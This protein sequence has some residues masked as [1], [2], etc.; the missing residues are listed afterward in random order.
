MNYEYYNPGLKKKIS[1]EVPDNKS[2]VLIYGKNGSGKTVFSES[3][4]FNKKYVFNEKFVREN[5]YI[6]TE[7]DLKTTASNRENFSSLFMGKDVVKLKEKLDLL[8]SSKRNYSTKREKHISIIKDKLD[9]TKIET[10]YNSVINL[11][12][13]NVEPINEL[14]EYDELLKE[15]KIKKYK[16]TIKD[17][18]KFEEKL[19]LFN[20]N[21]KIQSYINLVKE[22]TILENIVLNKDLS[23]YKKIFEEIE[24]LQKMSSIKK[25]MDS[26]LLKRKINYLK[27]DTKTIE[28][29]LKM[30][31]SNNICL[32][33]GAEDKLKEIKKWTNIISNKFEVKKQSIL[34]IIKNLLKDIE[35][36]KPLEKDVSQEIPNTV[37]IIADIKKELLGTKIKLEKSELEI[38]S[39]IKLIE[40]EELGKEVDE[41]Q[42]EL[43]DFLVFKEKEK[44]LGTEFQIKNQENSI[45]KTKKELEHEFEMLKDEVIERTNEILSKM[46]IDRKVNIKPNKR[47]YTLEFEIDGKDVNSLS[48]GERH[49]LAIAFFFASLEDEDLDNKTIVLDDPVVTLDEVSYHVLRK[50]IIKLRK[51][52]KDKNLKVIILTHNIFYLYVQISNLFENNDLKDEAIFFKMTP[53]KVTQKDID[54]LRVDDIVLFKTALNNLKTSDDLLILSGIV[55]KIFRHLLDIK[56]RISGNLFKNKP[57]EDIDQLL[58]KDLD[59]KRLKKIS[60]DI[61]DYTKHKSRFDINVAKELIC[62]LREGLTLLGYE[63]FVTKDNC[64]KIKDF[65]SDKTILDELEASNIYFEIINNA[66]DVIYRGAYPDIKDYLSHPRQQITKQ[67][68]S[69]SA[70]M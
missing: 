51:K 25:E 53:Q 5:I 15:A 6:T 61:N 20:N 40:I 37:K 38:E 13:E 52:Y 4:A 32:F 65:D 3:D 22:N 69:I 23:D 41:L 35:S 50:L 28:K 44:I 70:D 45:K 9:S 55:Y 1:F 31:G 64:E 46:Y 30:Q 57:S 26:F 67:I 29:M 49:K 7:E 34:F 48:D 43:I 14:V 11:R 12:L 59:K 10:T 63:D 68:T 62:K 58:L 16:T 36:L 54:I 21:S 60:S 2:F 47:N 56:N 42:K 27:I 33:C 17:Q 8:E 66:N 18:K 19:M 24:E 39:K